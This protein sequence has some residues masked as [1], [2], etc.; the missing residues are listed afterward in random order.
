MSGESRER[1]LT[2][3]CLLGR[4]WSLPAINSGTR[5]VERPGQICPKFQTTTQ[6]YC[7]KSVAE[8]SEDLAKTTWQRNTWHRI[9]QDPHS[10]EIDSG[11]DIE[12]TRLENSGEGDS[13]DSSRMP[14]SESNSGGTEFLTPYL[15]TGQGDMGGEGDAALQAGAQERCSMGADIVTSVRGPVVD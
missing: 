13:S 11:E 15:G 10:G 2:L 14:S 1:R 8:G 5:R 4:A 6:S 3:T 9:F 7:Q 12:T